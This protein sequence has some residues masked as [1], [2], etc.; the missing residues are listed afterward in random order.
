MKKR[1]DA[2]PF[3][4]LAALAVMAGSAAAGC[5]PEPRSVACADDSECQRP[6]KGLAYCINSRGVECV[7]SSLCSAEDRCIGG[8]CAPRCR[9][10]RDCRSDQLCREGTCEAR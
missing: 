7:S 6:D 8:R 10:T 5:A 1:T 4:L 2:A 3:P 9:D